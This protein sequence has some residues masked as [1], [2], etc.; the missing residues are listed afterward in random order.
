MKFRMKMT[1]R[2]ARPQLVGRCLLAAVFGLLCCP[3][4]GLAQA[5]PTSSQG[6]SNAARSPPVTIDQIVQA[7]RTRQQRA[8]SF[9]FEWIETRTDMKGGA[10]G[11]E[12][13]APLNPTKDTTFE[14]KCLLV[15]DGRKSNYTYDGYI[16][17]PEVDELLIRKYTCVYDGTESKD[18]LAAASDKYHPQGILFGA[19]P[20]FQ[21][22]T[23]PLRPPVW[24]YRSLDVELGGFDQARLTVTGD[25]GSIAGQDCNIVVQRS[26][27]AGNAYETKLWLDPSQGFAV[28][29]AVTM[30]A[31][32]VTTSRLDI[33]YGAKAGEWV[34]VR[35]V[36]VRTPNGEVRNQLDCRV[37]EFALNPEIPATTFEI[38][39]PPGTWVT[40]QRG[41]TLS[42]T[43]H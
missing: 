20:N 5:E 30:Y 21:L 43:P 32:R 27:G 36:Y 22:P 24:F 42:R 34:P 40:D 29:R 6:V 3:R 7:W 25:T 38:D 19:K 2:H 8:R 13:N 41:E 37:T 35:W 9:R 18:F 16:W 26:G 28:R 23:P 33:S 14:S 39:Y 11:P 12:P 17:G 15:V 4:E 31:G 10:M 1:D